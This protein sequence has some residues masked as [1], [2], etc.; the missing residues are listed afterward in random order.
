[1]KKIKPLILVVSFFVVPQFAFAQLSVDSDGDVGIDSNNPRFNLEIGNMG[2]VSAADGLGIKTDNLTGKKNVVR[3]EGPNSNHHFFAI[4]YNHN[5]DKGSLHFS[6]NSNSFDDFIVT[7]DGNIGMG[8]ETPSDKLS[9]VGDVSV[10]GTGPWA[11]FVFEEGYDLRSLE[12]VERFINENGH[13]PEIP[14]AAEVES[15]GIKLGQISSKFLQK[16][17]ELTLY[18]IQQEKDIR[19]LESLVLKQQQLIESMREVIDEL[20]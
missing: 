1:M 19:E 16:I 5:T 20:K 7:E 8:T 6:P 4:T 9:V 2:Y 10:T 15:D 3:I 12:N 18:T 17:E 14:T 11:D 13:L